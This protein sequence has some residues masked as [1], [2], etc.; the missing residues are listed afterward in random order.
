MSV[1]AGVT[2]GGQTVFIV[3][4]PLTPG[5]GD[6]GGQVSDPLQVFYTDFFGPPNTRPRPVQ[7]SPAGDEYAGTPGGSMGSGDPAGAFYSSGSPRRG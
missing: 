2:A 3:T 1:I 4:V 5:G 7:G 6:G